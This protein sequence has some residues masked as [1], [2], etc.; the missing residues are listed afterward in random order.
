LVDAILADDPSAV[1]EE[2]GDLLVEVA[3]QSAIAAERGMFELSELADAASLKMISRHPHV[4]G[5]TP[6]ADEL[7]LLRNW[8]RIKLQ[9]KP[10]RT[11]ALDG[12]PASLPAL[13]RAVLVQRRASRGAPGAAGLSLSSEP[14]SAVGAGLSAL[15]PGSPAAD[16][17]AGELLWRAV[18]ECQRL[19]V[20]PEAALRR[21]IDRHS[22]HYRA[23]E[24]GPA[25]RPE[26]PVT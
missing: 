9:E 16:P 22:D 19:G 14:L 26:P 6:V 24:P 15:E 8:D 21:A 7:E 10:H 18:V 1:Q 3:M 23:A 4:F 17:M 25:G 11:S 2:L 13:L 12:I 5:G 20:D